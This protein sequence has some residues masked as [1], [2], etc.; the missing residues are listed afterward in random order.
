MKAIRVHQFGEPD[1]L[2][3]EEV[4][5]PTPAA[6]QVVVRIKAVGVNPVETYIR[7]GRYGPRQFPFTPGNDGAGIIEAVGPGMR[8]WNKGDR[9]YVAGSISG[10]YAELA[11][12]DAKKVHRLPE[13]IS[14]ED[15][16]GLGVPAATAW[17]GLFQR[18]GAQRGEMLLVHGASGGV[19]TMAVQLARD[20]GLTIIGTAGSEKGR[21][22]VRSLGAQHVLDHRSADYLKE[23]MDLTQQRGVNLILEMAANVNLAKDLSILAKFG[24]VVIIGSRGTI[25]IDP[26]D[27]MSRD[28]DIRGMTL[29]NVNDQDYEAIHAGIVAMLEK[30]GLKAIIDMTLPLAEAARAHKLVLEG[31]SHGK[32]VLIP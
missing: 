10:T 17:R 30:G 20:A 12:C 31:E 13:K 22:L 3:L 25:E 26:R 7:A 15:G 18:G 5:D 6:G 21:E 29:F 9:V 28:A 24:R 4:P 32:I 8:Q 16:A 23:V 14:F 1:V 27:T 11:L 2:K 19:G